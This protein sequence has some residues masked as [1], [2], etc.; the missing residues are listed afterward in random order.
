MTDWRSDRRP[1]RRCEAAVHNPG[2][3]L[4][5]WTRDSTSIKWP[6]PAPVEKPSASCCTIPGAVVRQLQF[7]FTLQSALL[8][9]LS[10]ALVVLC[11]ILVNHSSIFI[12]ELCTSPRRCYCV[13]VS[14]AKSSQSPRCC[15]EKRVERLAQ[16][17]TFALRISWHIL[18][19]S[20]SVLRVTSDVPHSIP[21]QMSPLTSAMIRISAFSASLTCTLRL[22]PIFSTSLFEN[23]SGI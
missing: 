10:S 19:N 1:L 9:C 2:V 5:V 23:P 16:D 15:T 21:I 17:R 7:L 8:I 14:Q 18:D 13:G 12:A 6:R 11:A 3:G 4:W 22:P 20:R